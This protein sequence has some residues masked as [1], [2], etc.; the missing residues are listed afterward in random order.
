[1]WR[2]TCPPRRCRGYKGRWLLQQAGAPFPGGL[3]QLDTWLAQRASL[4]S[5]Y[6]SLSRLKTIGLPRGEVLRG[7]R[8]RSSGRRPFQKPSGSAPHIS[9]PL[10]LYG[11][12]EKKRRRRPLQKPPGG[13]ACPRCRGRGFTLLYSGGPDFGGLSFAREKMMKGNLDGLP[14]CSVAGGY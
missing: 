12:E 11:E 3:L 7:N 10:P 5:T 6:S 4:R 1:L 8:A 14:D 9:N 2:D 13:A